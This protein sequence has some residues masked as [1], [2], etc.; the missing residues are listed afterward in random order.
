MTYF[1]LVMLGILILM[2]LP[3][4]FSYIYTGFGKYM[5]GAWTKKG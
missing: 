4:F 5:D 3:G 2:I 1:S